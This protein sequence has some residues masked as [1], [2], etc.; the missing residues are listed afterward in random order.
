[1]SAAEP[2]AGSAPTDPLVEAC[3]ELTKHVYGKAQEIARYAE[4]DQLAAELKDLNQMTASLL[5]QA[6]KLGKKQATSEIK[7]L[8]KTAAKAH[9]ALAKAKPVMAKI[10]EHVDTLREAMR[11]LNKAFKAI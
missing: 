3:I 9:K 5:S 4:S 11:S 7:G 1:M 2:V 8:L 6:D 10:Q